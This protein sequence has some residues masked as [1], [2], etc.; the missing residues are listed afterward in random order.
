MKSK[1]LETKGAL[2]NSRRSLH[3]STTTN[4]GE[5]N[6][7]I[8]RYFRGDKAK[9]KKAA[10]VNVLAA[11]M[12][13]SPLV[14]KDAHDSLVSSGFVAQQAVNRK[15]KATKEEEEEDD[16]EEEEEWE[17][18]EEGDGPKDG[19]GV[20]TFDD[21]GVYD[22][23]WKDGMCDGEGIYVWPNGATYD[24]EWKDGKREGVGTFD[25]AGG[26][27]NGRWKGGTREGLGTFEF[28]G[29]K[30]DG[31]WEG[32]KAAGV[33]VL[34]DFSNGH[35]KVGQYKAGRP[36]GNGVRWNRD[37]SRACLTV[38]GKSSVAGKAPDEISQAQAEQ[39]ARSLGLAL[40]FSKLALKS[41][42][43]ALSALIITT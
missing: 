28:A 42:F 27:Y 10:H 1:K 35:A 26:K 21:G 38:D 2:C 37:R 43:D 25:F 17:D 31:G 12:K 18:E 22:G 5:I 23:E 13:G 32:G 6:S 16:D 29:G 24:G 40:S 15:K 3:C 30:Y 34:F 19:K 11:L 9:G 7:L 39:F 4:A 14:L 20:F 41:N 33:G 8:V 36:I